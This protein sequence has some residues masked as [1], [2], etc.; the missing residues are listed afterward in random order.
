MN[1]GM[2]CSLKLN[3]KYCGCIKF[4]HT[5]NNESADERWNCLLPPSWPLTPPLDSYLLYRNRDLRCQSGIFGHVS[6]VLCKTIRS[7]A[8]LN[9]EQYSVGQEWTFK[10]NLIITLYK[11]ILVKVLKFV[12]LGGRITDS[13]WFPFFILSG[14]KKE[15]MIQTLSWI[16]AMKHWS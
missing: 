15:K 14:S 3:Q 16:S 5:L 9:L 13:L 8:L 7:E 4:M 6:S 2:F 12:F 10:L 1:T 11:K